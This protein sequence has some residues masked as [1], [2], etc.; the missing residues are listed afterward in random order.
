MT[1]LT[2]AAKDLIT[3]LL[4]VD[5]DKR[6]TI[7]EFIAHPWS[8]E[9][10]PKPDLTPTTLSQAGP[11]LQPKPAAPASAMPLDSPMLQAQMGGR[12]PRA[13]PGIAQLREAF[14]VTYAVHRM[15]EVRWA[16]CRPR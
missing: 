9:Q 12:M 7:D 14:D 3:H 2:V 5:P 4:C 16:L 10:P 13:S 15:E 8:Q 1:V 6:S 11:L